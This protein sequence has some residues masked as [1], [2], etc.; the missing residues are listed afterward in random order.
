[1]TPSSVLRSQGS[2]ATW[3]HNATKD[4]RIDRPGEFRYLVSSVDTSAVADL[5]ILAL[6]GWRVRVGSG[7]NRGVRVTITRPSKETP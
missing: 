2:P 1:M 7:P 4:H 3:L 5:A 6:E